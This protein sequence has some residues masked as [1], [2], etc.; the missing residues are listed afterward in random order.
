MVRW[1]KYGGRGT[2]VVLFGLLVGF[3]ASGCGSSTELTSSW[4]DH[5]L[6][7]ESPVAVWDTNLVALKDSHVSLAVRNDTGYVYLCLVT[8]EAQFRRQMMAPGMTVWVE[9]PDGKKLGIHYPMGFVNVQ[10]LSNPDE[11]TTEPPQ[12]GQM[13]QQALNELEILGPG[14]N[15]RNILSTA[16]LHDMSVKIDN[17]Q[18]ES[19]YELKLPLH[20]SVDHPYAAGANAGSTLNVEIET[21]KIESRRGEGMS[22]EGGEGGG[23]RGGGRRGGFGGGYGHGGGGG[24]YGG[25]RR[26]GEGG[27][28]NAG[29]NRPEPLDLNVKVYLANADHSAKQ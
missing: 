14:K 4:T 29:A 16:E 22:R 9:S 23:M 25:G 6:Q 21:G 15:D 2:I 11:E 17:V 19:V 10:S 20:E 26:G 1:I 24:G 7:T 3:A 8:P 12:R 18:G 27:G 13:I 5:Q 28:N